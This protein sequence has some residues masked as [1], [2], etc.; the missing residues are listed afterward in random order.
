MQM[1]VEQNTGHQGWEVKLGSK[2]GGPLSKSLI[3]LISAWRYSFN[4]KHRKKK[5]SLLSKE[6]SKEKLLE[7]STQNLQIV[8]VT[9]LADQM[10]GLPELDWGK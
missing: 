8:Y 7:W 1:W 4:L 9:H 6:G 3:S 10:L 2:H 5:T